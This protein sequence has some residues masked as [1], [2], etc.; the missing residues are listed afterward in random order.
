M[1][2]HENVLKAVA[3][4][5]VHHQRS[6]RAPPNDMSNSFFASPDAIRPH[7]PASGRRERNRSWP[8]SKHMGGEAE[9][10]A[11]EAFAC[12]GVTSAPVASPRHV[13]GGSLEGGAAKLSVGPSVPKDVLLLQNSVGLKKIGLWQKGGEGGGTS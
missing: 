8:T 12:V 7:A 11:L 2:W 3:D 10:M 13:K 6:D 9:S 4:A 5:A 1:S